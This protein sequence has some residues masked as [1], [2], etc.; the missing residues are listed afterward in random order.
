MRITSGFECVVACPLSR[1]GYYEPDQPE[2]GDNQRLEVS[3]VFTDATGTLAA[4]EM[5]ER[6]AKRLEARLRLLMP[7]EVPYT[8]PLSKPAVPVEF[9]EG[10]IRTLA[11]RVPMEIAANIYLCRDKQRTLRLI[12]KTG[13]LVIM[14]GRKGWWPT[15]AQRLAGTL[16]RDGHHV[17]FTELR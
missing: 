13:S 5:A 16:E 8:L 15:P 2:N 6:L 17:I 14:G 11:S 9:L 1:L 10:Q 4:L 12:L 3:V 7:Y